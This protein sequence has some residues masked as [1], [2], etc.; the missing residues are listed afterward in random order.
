MNV[1]CS[2]Q[3]NMRYSLDFDP[4]FR[5]FL[6]QM[7]HTNNREIKP[8]PAT[9]EQKSS[10]NFAAASS[11]I[12]LDEV[13][14][15][16]MNMNESFGSRDM[17]VDLNSTFTEKTLSCKKSSYMVTTLESLVKTENHN[18]N[19]SKNNEDDAESKCD[20]LHTPNAKNSTENTSLESESPHTPDNGKPCALPRHFRLGLAELRPKKLISSHTKGNAKIT[21]DFCHLDNPYTLEK[22]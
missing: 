2:S 5:A 19:G 7:S 21:Y 11:E 13:C 12:F 22:T 9:S 6:E 4:E 1:S 14:S 8:L 16:E 10:T 3:Q 17:D 15:S 18:P 20:S